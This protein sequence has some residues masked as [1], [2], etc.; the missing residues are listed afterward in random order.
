M[1]GF[2][3]DKELGTLA[4]FV[5]ADGNFFGSSHFFLIV[6]IAIIVNLALLFYCMRKKKMENDDR[7]QS[8]VQ[9]QVEKYFK[10]QTDTAF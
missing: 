7:I 8:Q 9:L 5:Q 10:L 1:K 6:C 4:D 2:Q 3:I